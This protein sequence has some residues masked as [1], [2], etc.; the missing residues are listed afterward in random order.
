MT[1]LLRQKQR[2]VRQQSSSRTT[3]PPDR[4]RSCRLDR[5]VSRGVDADGDLRDE[6]DTRLDRGEGGQSNFEID[7]AAVGGTVKKPVFT[8]GANLTLDG[9][10]P[11]RDWYDVGEGRRETTP[12]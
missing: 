1:Q 7:A 11:C 8:A 6:R 5:R 9:A 3:R 10:S 2:A 12:T 4:D